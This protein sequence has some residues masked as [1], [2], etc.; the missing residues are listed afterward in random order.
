V[1]AVALMLFHVDSGFLED[2][3]RGIA[4]LKR[5]IVLAGVHPK[6]PEWFAGGHDIAPHPSPPLPIVNS[7]TSL[8]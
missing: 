1:E 7:E 3:Y 5:N 2:G 6:E 8:S 4:I